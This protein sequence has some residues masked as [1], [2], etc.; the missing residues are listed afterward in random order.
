MEFAEVPQGVDRPC[1]RTFLVLRRERRVGGAHRG[2]G[3]RVEGGRAIPD[4]Q[5][6]QGGAR[7]QLRIEL[8][9]A[10]RD[11][12]RPALPARPGVPVLLRCKGNAMSAACAKRRARRDGVPMRTCLTLLLCATLAAGADWPAWRGPDR[13][14][15]SA[16]TGLLKT[17]PEGAPKLLWQ[18]D[19]AGLGYAGMAVVGGTVYTMG[20]RD[21]DGYLIALDDKGQEK[22][23][24]K[25]GP[26][27]D[28]KANQWSLG[29]NATPTVDGDRIYAL[30]SRGTLLCTDRNGKEVWRLDLVKDL[31]GQVNPIA[32]GY[33]EGKEILGWGYCWSPFVDSDKL[34]VTPGGPKGLFAALDKKTGTPLWRSAAVTDQATYA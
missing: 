10:S 23:A 34:V 25:I 30:S 8:L 22:W 19:K 31:E 5:A 15:V 32:G 13:T 33:E 26:S 6:E 17:W 3:R 4:P 1:R 16:E 11:R 12:E 14:G 28:W 24:T 9:D 27:Y 2:D 7:L 21:K 20:L 18:S 29:P